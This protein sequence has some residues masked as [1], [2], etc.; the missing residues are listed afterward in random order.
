LRRRK[1]RRRPLEWPPSLVLR[2]L[3]IIVDGLMIPRQ[4][5]GRKPRPLVDAADRQARTAALIARCEALIAADDQYLRDREQYLAQNLRLGRALRRIADLE[6]EVTNWQ[7]CALETAAEA[8][9]RLELQGDDLRRAKIRVG[10]L[11]GLRDVRQT[12]RSPAAKKRYS[13][14]LVI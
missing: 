4:A 6:D 14:G 3:R 9:V 7:N 2:A 10:Q 5:I 12:T 1:R 13:G 8:D 11:E